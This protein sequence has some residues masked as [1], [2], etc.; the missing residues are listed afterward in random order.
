MKHSRA[1]IRIGGGRR[2]ARRMKQTPQ[3][4]Q[5]R[6]EQQAETGEKSRRN[7]YAE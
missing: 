3:S 7:L 1:E 6:P 4:T 2:T 5:P